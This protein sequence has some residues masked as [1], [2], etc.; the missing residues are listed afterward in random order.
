MPRSQIMCYTC[1]C[2][3]PN[4]AHGDHRNLTNHGFDVA[5]EAMNIS[6]TEA[7]KNA[8]DL[9]EKVDPSSGEV[10]ESATTTG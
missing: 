5:A 3:D 2:G 4:D 1:G 6:A 9:L 10:R 7:R 8:T